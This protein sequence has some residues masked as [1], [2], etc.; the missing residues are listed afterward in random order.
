[1]HALLSHICKQPIIA[2]YFEPIIGLYS[3]FET[4]LKFYNLGARSMLLC[5][6]YLAVDIVS[7]DRFLLEPV[8]LHRLIRTFNKTDD[9][10]GK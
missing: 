2:L 6:L 1:M 5:S 8:E 9:G 3:E 10:H 7:V 4:V